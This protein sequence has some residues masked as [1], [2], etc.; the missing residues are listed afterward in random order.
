MIMFTGLVEA[1]GKVV[2]VIGSGT[3]RRVFIETDLDVSPGDSVA[4][5]GVCLTVEDVIER[6]FW[7]YMSR[8]TLEVSKFGKTLRVSSKVNLERALLANSRLGGHF[9]LGHVD[10]IGRITAMHRESD[11]FIWDIVLLKPEFSKYIVYKGSIAVDGVSLT[12]NSVSGSRFSIR[13]I[14][15][16]I[17]HTNFSDRKIGDLVN[18]EFDIIAKYVEK[19]TLGSG[20]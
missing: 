14:P 13:L 6:G 10:S 20:K 17:S 5:D 12:V 15:F 16:T 4:V 11:S 7:T 18:L 2:Q 3:G 9:V 19:L 8:E 1:V